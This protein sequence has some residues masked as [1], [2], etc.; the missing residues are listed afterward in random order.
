MWAIC[1]NSIFCINFY[2][3]KPLD[4]YFLLDQT[5][6]SLW[7]PSLTEDFKQTP[8]SAL[9]WCDFAGAKCLVHTVYERT[10]YY[11]YFIIVSL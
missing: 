8:K 10:K 2:E 6:Y 9:R 4:T 7:W 11:N 5:I 1:S 3:G